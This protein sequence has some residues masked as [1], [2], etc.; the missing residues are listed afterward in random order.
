MIFGVGVQ[1]EC[2]VV[3]NVGWPLFGSRDVGYFIT[4]TIFLIFFFLYERSLMQRSPP[5]SLNCSFY[6]QRNGSL[7]YV[8]CRIRM[9]QKILVL[10]L[11]TIC[12]IR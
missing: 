6:L 11:Y 4:V 12:K 10:F 8:F 1:R 5:V 7:C 9:N 2:L 3:N